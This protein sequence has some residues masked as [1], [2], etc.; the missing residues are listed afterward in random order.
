MRQELIDLFDSTLNFNENNC[1]EIYQKITTSLDKKIERNVIRATLITLYDNTVNDLENTI[2]NELY[3]LIG[4][5]ALSICIFNSFEEYEYSGKVYD[6]M[7]D[8]YVQSI[9]LIEKNPI[10]QNKLKQEF[11]SLFT[12]IMNKITENEEYK[13]NH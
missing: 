4:D 12:E 7:S 2:V 3:E 5:T 9:M 1:Y 11:K 13:N 8:L 10:N 6:K